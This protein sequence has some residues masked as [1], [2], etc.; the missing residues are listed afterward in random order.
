MVLQARA[1]VAFFFSSFCRLPKSVTIAAYHTSMF[2]LVFPSSTFC[3][4]VPDQFA[5]TAHHSAVSKQTPPL[6]NTREL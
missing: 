3:P 5:A 4:P 2:N 6:P 1:L